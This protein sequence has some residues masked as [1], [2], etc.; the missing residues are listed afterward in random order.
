MASGLCTRIPLC[1]D[2]RGPHASAA[3]GQIGGSWCGRL[4]LKAAGSV[5]DSGKGIAQ[6]DQAHVFELF[7]STKGEVLG[8]GLSIRRSIIRV[9]RGHIWAENCEGR[10]AIF[11]CVIAHSATSHGCCWAI[12]GTYCCRQRV[13]CR[14]P[15]RPL[16][17][18]AKMGTAGIGY[19]VSKRFLLAPAFFRHGLFF[20]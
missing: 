8:M 10:G 14:P 9:H 2:S 18:L 6:M 17:L 16:G 13:F 19:Y 11:H 3:A 4:R 1:L 20:L 5:E 12:D 7:F 15:S